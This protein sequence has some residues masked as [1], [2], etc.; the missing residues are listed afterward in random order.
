MRFLISGIILI[1]LS[2][3]N[4]QEDSEPEEKNYCSLNEVCDDCVYCDNY[5]LCNFSNIFCYQNSSHDY[6]RIQQLENDLSIYFQKDHNMQ[7]FCNSRSISLNSAEDDFKILESP[8]N[9][10]NIILNKSYHCAYYITNRYYFNHETDQAKIN[11]EIKRINRANSLINFFLLFIYKTEKNWLFFRFND[12]QLRSSGFSKVLDQISEVHILIDFSGINTPGEIS[13]S[14]VLSITTQNPS[15]NLRK[16]Y[17]VIIIFLCFFILVIIA[18]FVVYYCLKKKMRREQE[19]RIFEEREKIEK[20]KKMVEDFLKKNLSPQIFSEKLNINDCDSC[21][22]CCENFIIG[23][24]EVSITPCSHV[25]HHECISKW[26]KEKINNPCCP[27]CNFQFLE[28]IKN[29]DKIKT[30]NK[31]NIEDKKENKEDK[32]EM[33]R[34]NTR[35]NEGILDNNSNTILSENLRIKN[36]QKEEENIDNEKSININITGNDDNGGSN[37]KNDNNIENENNIIK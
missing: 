29:P 10:N 37:I 30:Y 26:V 12:N 20:D 8:T 25:F 32:K 9:R 14:L 19:R 27:N 13:E 33:K 6:N 15:E 35:N 16:I 22:I 36:Q 3:I 34:I 17:I 21:T 18:L 2:Y 31:E 4:C 28:Y 24:S 1:L 5:T 11:L 7:S 23:Q